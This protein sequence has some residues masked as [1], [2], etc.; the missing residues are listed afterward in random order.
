MFTLTWIINAKGVVMYRGV[1]LLMLIVLTGCVNDQVQEDA[2]TINYPDDNDRGNQINVIAQKLNV[3]WDITHNDGDFI[4]SERQGKII[5]IS[6]DSITELTLQLKEN[7][8]AQTES[9]LLGF[10]LAPDFDNSN[11]AY[12]YHTYEENGN[13]K[14]RVIQVKLENDEWI[15]TK[16]L[17]EDIPGG[18]IHNGGRIKFGPDQKLYVTTGDAGIKELAQDQNSLAGKI[19]RMNLDGSIPEDNPFADS[20]VY[21][22]GHRNPQGMTWGDDGTMYSS[23]HGQSAHDEINRI[24]AG[25]NYGWPVIEGDQTKDGMVTPLFHSSEE[26]WA[27]SGLVYHEGSLYVACLRDEQIRKFDLKQNESYSIFSSAGRLRDTIIIDESLYTVTNN[28]DGRGEPIE[29]DDRLIQLNLEQI[30]QNLN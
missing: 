12:L 2:E 21:S 9:G 25:K 30:N 4:L 27:P 11:N 23:E 7:V 10:T 18:R 15:E 22:Y 16:V 13:L 29:S 6:G 24:E 19:L 20:Y 14:N 1:L 28:R 3:P 17:L 8:A 26:T 5:H